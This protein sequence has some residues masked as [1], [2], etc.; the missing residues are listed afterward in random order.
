MLEGSG[1]YL[2]QSQ[3]S[4]TLSRPLTDTRSVSE[5]LRGQKWECRT[6][7]QGGVNNW[8]QLIGNQTPILFEKAKLA[9]PL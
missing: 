2:K 6:T 5:S 8:L 1:E 7:A 9:F 4:L 3:I